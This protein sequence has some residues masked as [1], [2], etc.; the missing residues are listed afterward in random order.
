M[1]HELFLS[2]PLLG[3]NEGLMLRSWWFPALHQL[4]GW[5]GSVAD[6]PGFM[7]QQRYI[8]SM[9]CGKIN[10]SFHLRLLLC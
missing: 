10:Q 9:K 1:E 2:S 8:Y 3:E 6:G 5:A 7:L 4:T